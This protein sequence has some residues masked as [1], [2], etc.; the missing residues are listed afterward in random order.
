MRRPTDVVASAP[1][2]GRFRLWSHRVTIAVFAGALLLLAADAVGIF[3]SD[4]AS[5]WLG[6]TLGIAGLTWVLY[7]A[8]FVFT[9]R[10]EL[11]RSG[12]LRWFGA[13]RRGSIDVA[14]IERVCTDAAPFLW[15]IHHA[16]GR[17]IVRSSPT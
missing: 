7:W 10:L 16:H 9:L 17:L 15:T 6:I 3:G 14:D 1:R 4:P 11:T 2:G 12:R 13:L 8:G 5:N